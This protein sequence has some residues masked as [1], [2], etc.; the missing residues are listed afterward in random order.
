[1]I[2]LGI[3]FAA[4]RLKA[5]LPKEQG[6]F[7]RIAPKALLSVAALHGCLAMTEE[8]TKPGKKN[9][10]TNKKM[11]VRIGRRSCRPRNGSRKNETERFLLA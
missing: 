9:R 2:V 6:G 8:G 4:H 5:L 10:E 3:V 7:E 11:W 1:M